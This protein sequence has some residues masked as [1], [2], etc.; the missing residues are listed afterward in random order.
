MAVPP[1][2]IG[3]LGVAV[4]SK[5]VPPAAMLALTEV[6]AT[7]PVFLIVIDAAVCVPYPTVAAGNV[8]LVGLSVHTGP[9]TGLTVNDSVT[10]LLP[11]L[12]V[13]TLNVPV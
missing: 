7:V 2:S 12:P 6:N 8:W 1:A 3:V 10:S 4:I 13:L 11:P 9:P 5:L